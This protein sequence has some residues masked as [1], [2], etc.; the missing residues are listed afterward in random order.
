MNKYLRSRHW[1]KQRWFARQLMN[2]VL[3]ISLAKYSS[4]SW[5]HFNVSDI[6]ISADIYSC[7]KLWFL[8]LCWWSVIPIQG[9]ASYSI[10]LLDIRHILFYNLSIGHMFS[11]SDY[12]W[13]SSAVDNRDTVLCQFKIIDKIY[14]RFWNSLA[15]SALL[16]LRMELLRKRDVGVAV[17]SS[18]ILSFEIEHLFVW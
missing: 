16:P 14:Q 9:H 3:F 5:W 13:Q 8:N 11:I 6:V 15:Y 2:D 17:F 18:H 1:C 10:L 12:V 4:W 7:R